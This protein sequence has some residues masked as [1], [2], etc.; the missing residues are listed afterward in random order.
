MGDWDYITLAAETICRAVKDLLTPH[1]ELETQRWLLDPDNL[2][3][4]ALRLP[5]LTRE[6]IDKLKAS[7]RH[8]TIYYSIVRSRAGISEHG[9]K[10]N[11]Q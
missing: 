1:Y 5:V 7:Q 8:R 6:Q 10:G 11:A 3:F 2:C 4:H 9:R